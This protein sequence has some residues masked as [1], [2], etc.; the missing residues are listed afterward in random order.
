MMGIDWRDGIQSI[1]PVNLLA[2][3]GD[4]NYVLDNAPS[5]NGAKAGYFTPG[6]T[7]CRSGFAKNIRVRYSLTY[8]GTPYYQNVYWIKSRSRPREYSGMG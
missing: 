7:N 5:N 2:N 8:G 3:P 1:S 6:H 4:I